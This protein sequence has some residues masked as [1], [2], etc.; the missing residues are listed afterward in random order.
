MNSE[1]IAEKLASKIL[2]RWLGEFTLKESDT[3]RGAVWASFYVAADFTM[4][5]L[6]KAAA[7]VGVEVFRAEAS[8]DEVAAMFEADADLGEVVVRDAGGTVWVLRMGGTGGEPVVFA[9]N[10]VGALRPLPDLAGPLTVMS[11]ASL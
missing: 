3:V 8:T 4:K 7:K 9:R 6:A 1:E 2:K 5:E 10:F 11:P